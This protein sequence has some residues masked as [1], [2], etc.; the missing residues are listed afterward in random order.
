[1][2]RWVGVCIFLLIY[3]LSLTAQGQPP[4]PRPP[5]QAAAIHIDVTEGEGAL[6]SI[7]MHRAH[8]PVVR[9]TDAAG[10]P[11]AGATVTFHLPATGPSATLPDGGV[12]STVQTDSQGIAE[13]HGLRPNSRAGEF[14]I[15][16]TAS[17]HGAVAQAF[18]AQTNA[19]P[20]ARSGHTKLYV[21]LAAV[22]GAAA[23]GAVLA[24][25]GKSSPAETTTAT[26]S[27]TAGSPIFGPP[28]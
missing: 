26:G 24:M 7:R 28:H 8:D 2:W 14:Q 27:I 12:T 18:L 13:A 16:V 22:A 9:V 15:R 25:R 5:S 4:G 21:I 10:A 20:V 23:G 3:S 11:V 6:N 19:E 1:M 17:W